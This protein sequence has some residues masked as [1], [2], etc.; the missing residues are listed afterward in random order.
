[1]PSDDDDKIVNNWQVSPDPSAPGA[2]VQEVFDH[3]SM[4]GNFPLTQTRSTR[5]ASNT[6]ALSQANSLLDETAEVAMRFDSITI[7]PTTTLGFQECLGLTIS[8]RVTVV[9]T[10]GASGSTVT[11]DCFIEGIGSWSIRP[12][13]AGAWAV[14]FPLS[15][16][17]SGNYY[18]TI[19]RDGPVSYWRDDTIT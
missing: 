4:A 19:I 13:P 3:P 10:P 5:L 14:S 9:R 11:K 8:D 18:M 6:D 1:M 15:P 2:A 16:V 17:T 7:V 12:G